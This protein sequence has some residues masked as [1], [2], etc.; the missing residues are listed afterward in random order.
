MLFG[1]ATAE[2][3]VG[4]ASGAAIVSLV[5]AAVTTAAATLNN[6]INRKHDVKV[7]LLESRLDDCEKR[8]AT[9]E[10]EIAA[11]RMQMTIPKG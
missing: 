7:A 2:Q 4:M 8:H 11:L 5:G 6:W 1:D 3:A 9:Q 10:R